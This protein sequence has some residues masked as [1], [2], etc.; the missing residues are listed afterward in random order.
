MRSVLIYNVAGEE[1]WGETVHHES[2]FGEKKRMIQGRKMNKTYMKYAQSLS[3]PSLFIYF[4]V[5]HLEL[6][7]KHCLYIIILLL[8]ASYA[9]PQQRNLYNDRKSFA[10]MYPVGFIKAFSS[11]TVMSS[12]NLIL[13]V[14]TDERT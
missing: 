1:R 2:V 14:T 6:G 4:R 10:E 13:P 5:L 9:L 11:H 7:R 3:F 8:Q 12:E